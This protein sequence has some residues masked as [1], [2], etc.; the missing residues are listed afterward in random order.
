MD[1]SIVDKIVQ[2]I[3]GFLGK[4]GVQAVSGSVKEIVME[5]KS[6]KPDQK[7]VSDPIQS[8]KPDQ[9]APLTKDDLLMGRDKAYAK[10]Y[11]PEISANLDK[12]LPV[13]NKIQEKYGKKFKINSG[14]RPAEVNGATPGAAAHSKHM[15]G[16][17][18][19]I[20]DADGDIMRWTL[21]NLDFIKSLGVHMEDWRWTPTWTHYQIVPPK[22]GNMIFIPSTA[23]A[24]AP[25]RWIGTYPS[26]YNG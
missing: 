25:T 8:V 13:L 19:D 20:A 16:L 6:V 5:E 11:T 1:K 26:K 17:A 7:A 2:A 10:E 18:A 22:S 23:P 21:A 15:E 12:L 4:Q 14:W 3:M 9:V 24:L